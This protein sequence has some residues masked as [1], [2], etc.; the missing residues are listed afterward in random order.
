MERSLFAQ[1]AQ[2]AKP[3]LVNGKVG[4]VFPPQG[5]LVRAL[6]FTFTADR[7][8]RIEVVSDPE[9]L[10]QLDLAVLTER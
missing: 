4:L 5:K 6:N 2:F 1:S 10:R 9:R 7:I 8:A 3:A